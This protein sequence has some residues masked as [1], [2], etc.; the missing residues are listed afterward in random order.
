MLSSLVRLSRPEWPD[1]VWIPPL[2]FTRGTRV[3]DRYLDEALP[4][5]GSVRA[6]QLEFNKLATVIR[7]EAGT[8]ELVSGAV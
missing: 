1:A 5:S 7:Q 8:H 4:V 3:T 6:E 2:S